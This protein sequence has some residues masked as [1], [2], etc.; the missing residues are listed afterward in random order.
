M[1]LIWLR[2]VWNEIARSRAIS[3]AVAPFASEETIS[4]SRE[5]SR[6]EFSCSSESNA[7]TSTRSRQ[8]VG[9]QKTRSTNVNATDALALPQFAA[10]R[11]RALVGSFGRIL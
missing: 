8:N 11:A 5:L 7:I 2:T 3:L 1:F 10:L 9:G 6:I 4:R